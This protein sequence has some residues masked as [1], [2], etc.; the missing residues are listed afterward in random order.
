MQREDMLGEIARL[1]EKLQAGVLTSA[2]FDLGVLAVLEPSS[3]EASPPTTSFGERYPYPIALAYAHLDDPAQSWQTRRTALHFTV[4]QAMR[5]AVLP[6]VGQHLGREQGDGDIEATRSFEKALTRLQ[7]PH[8]SDWITAVHT[9]RRMGSRLGL[10]LF[11]GLEPHGFHEGVRRLAAR[12]ARFQG[13]EWPLLEA[14]REL[15]N[16]TGHGGLLPE[17]ACQLAFEQFR[18]LV[19]EVLRCFEFLVGCRLVAVL[20]DHPDRQLELRG[21]RPQ[22][23]IVPEPLPPG[24]PAVHLVVPGRPPQ[25]MFPLLHPWL[26]EEPLFAYDGHY[27]RSGSGPAVIRYLGTGERRDVEDSDSAPSA[28]RTL[29]DLWARRQERRARALA[30]GPEPLRLLAA[31]ATR[32]ALEALERDLPNQAWPASGHQAEQVLSGFLQESGGKRGLL[33]LGPPRSGKSALLLRSLREQVGNHA[34]LV[35]GEW[36]SWRLPGKGA[37]LQRHLW[38]LLGGDGS[39]S[40]PPGDLVERLAAAGIVLVLDGLDQSPHCEE[41]VREALERLERTNLRLVLTLRPETVEILARS[42]WQA[43]HLFAPVPGRR[44]PGLPPFLE[45]VAPRRTRVAETPQASWLQRPETLHSE[46]PGALHALAALWMERGSCRVDASGAAEL[47]AGPGGLSPLELLLLQGVLHKDTPT[48]EPLYSMPDPRDREGLLFR[49]LFGDGPISAAASREEALRAGVTG[50]MPEH[51]GVFEL[52]L[53]SWILTGARRAAAEFLGDPDIPLSVRRRAAAGA[54]GGALATEDPAG[55]LGGLLGLCPP[56]SRE[57]LCLARTLLWDLEPRLRGLLAPEQRTRLLEDVRRALHACLAAPGLADDSDNAR[58]CLLVC[59]TRL[60]EAAQDQGD[61]L[62][63]ERHLEAALELA[64][65]RFRQREGHPQ[66][67][68]DLVES[69]LRLARLRLRGGRL[70]EARRLAEEAL[71]VADS[72]RAE[73][74]ACSTLVDILRNSRSLDA[75]RP[76]LARALRAARRAGREEGPSVED[77]GALQVLLGRAADLHR[78]CGRARRSARL[79]ETLVRRAEAALVRDPGDLETARAVAI[80]NGRLAQLERELEDL[81]SAVARARRSVDISRDLVA[82]LP[83]S[84]VDRENLAVA[85]AV[86]AEALSA[87]GEHEEASA[88]RIALADLKQ[89]P[90][91]R[92]STSEGNSGCNLR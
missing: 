83:E 23:P 11:E 50:A 68:R 37:Q 60:A 10:D 77:E 31:A 12:T 90:D 73:A 65:S 63:A 3:R 76:F 61:L 74:S 44:L 32:E 82:R 72:P 75:L 69:L 62:S 78:V 70:Q 64:R 30:S 17:K 46:L 53:R 22:P 13:R 89:Q 58:R 4:Y 38:S 16:A 87:R 66:P 2:E 42:L 15:R 34:L 33:V 48:D 85:L 26:G 14:F 49:H 55:C 59:A 18:D 71:G 52:V 28:C 51:G 27:V 47:D 29:Q 57:H 8:F 88:T 7:S 39:R 6:L 81:E 1:R 79:L 24:G 41:V 43:A 25:G 54:A 21:S 84:R 20:G 19:D 36:L 92:Q 5:M 40:A 91:Q 35:R 45:V 56:G 67:A 86:L 80:S 9:A